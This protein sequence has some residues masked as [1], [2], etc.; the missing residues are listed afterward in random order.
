[1]WAR[2]AEDRALGTSIGGCLASVCSMKRLYRGSH[3]IVSAEAERLGV[4]HA[5][6]W[7]EKKAQCSEN[8]KLVI[9]GSRG[10]KRKSTG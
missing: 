4:G 3:R 2:K 10:H 8:P 6:A 5:L 7:V 1:M 9:R